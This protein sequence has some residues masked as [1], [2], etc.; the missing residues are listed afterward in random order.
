MP[1]SP[2]IV[3]DSALR[4][5]AL[6]ESEDSRKDAME[7]ARVRGVSLV[8]IEWWPEPEVSLLRYISNRGFELL[9]RL[10]FVASPFA[11]ERFKA[12][13]FMYQN[14][15]ANKKP[16][17]QHSIVEIKLMILKDSGRVSYIDEGNQQTTIT[18]G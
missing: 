15:H 17:R 3:A 13:E 14:T 8:M 1:P 5:L 7:E 16:C 9:T 12:S 11:L 10:P 18:R 6:D 4:G 2:S